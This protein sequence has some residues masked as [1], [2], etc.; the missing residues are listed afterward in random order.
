MIYVD[1]TNAYPQRI[2]IPRDDDVVITGHTGSTFYVFQSK[3]YEISEN[4][5]TVIQP[6]P[7]YDAITAGTIS[8][9]VP[10]ATGDTEFVGL[11]TSENGIYVPTGN[12]AYSSV[13]V[14]VDTQAYYDHG[15]G[16]GYASGHTDGF[17]DGYSSGYTEG[18][19]SG[20]TDGYQNG[21]NSGKT[22]GYSSGYTEG[23]DA[24]KALLTTTA[25]TENGIY[26][27]ENGWSA[28]TVAVPAGSGST[29]EEGYSDGYDNGYNIGYSSGYTD[30]VEAQKALLGELSAN[31]NGT[32]TSE[33]GYSAVTVNVP[34]P[35][36]TSVTI[37][38]N[39][40]TTTP[41]QGVDGFNSVDVSIDTSPYYDDGF[42]AGRVSGYN[43]GYG[44]GYNAGEDAQKALLTS[45]TITQNGTYQREN[46]WD[47][48]NVEL[49]LNSTRITVNGTYSASTQSLVGYSVVEVDVPQT[50]AQIVT[51]TQAQYNALNPPD[52]N[53]IY[54]IKD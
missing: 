49:P 43:E 27:N 8:V 3:N 37:T 45:T 50:G 41:E 6:D 23:M 40:S 29:Y 33:T 12:T 51:C 16:D 28:V 38:V 2:F 31:T 1:N 47:E 22:D 48:V 39:D 44:D 25:I 10:P 30:G 54:L 15:Y 36:L 26:T 42:E 52:P 34:A 20:V 11:E 53:I 35:V 24:Q 32:Y 4:G 17:E 7:G 21:Y 5:L 18:Y 9:F 14:S 46:G 19:A 13:T